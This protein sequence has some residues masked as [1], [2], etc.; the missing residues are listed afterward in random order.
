MK[1][2]A[3]CE[4][5]EISKEKQ[6][7]VIALSL[8][9]NDKDRIREKVFSLVNLGKK[10]ELDTLIKFLDSHLKKNELT[11]SVK[12]IE[13]FESFQRSEGQS[14]T[15]FISLFDYYNRKIEK[16][17]MKLPSEILAFKLIRNANISKEEKFLVLK[18]M[19]YLNKDTLY[20]EAKLSLKKFKGDMTHQKYIFYLKIN[21]KPTTLEKY[22][23]AFVVDGYDK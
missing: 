10:H 22:E 4:V 16:L 12:K 18:G 19:H 8:P 2:Q 7:I 1:L 23:E 14:I 6:G 5:T 3:W 20:E 11:D 17:N 21:V 13:A 15:E 9:E